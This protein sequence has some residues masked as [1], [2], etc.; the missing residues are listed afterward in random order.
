MVVF[1]N[2]G[3]FITDFIAKTLSITYLDHLTTELFFLYIAI[4]NL[5]FRIIVISDSYVLHKIIF[6]WVLLT[7]QFTDWLFCGVTFTV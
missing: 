3:I 7:I 1:G 2:D 6:L 5:F 4:F